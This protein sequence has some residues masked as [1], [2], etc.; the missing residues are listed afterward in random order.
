M[1]EYEKQKKTSIMSVLKEALS[2]PG[3]MGLSMRIK[4]F[5]T[6]IVLLITMFFG[7]LVVLTITGTFTAGL[8]ET[9]RDIDEQLTHI[10]KDIENQ[11]GQL[12]IQGVELSEELSSSI[13]RKLADK[14]LTTRDLKNHPEVLEEIIS[15]EYDRCMFALLRSKSSGVFMI[16]DS[17]VNP[18]LNNG[19]NSRAG[20]YIKNN[21]P[22]ILSSSS[23]NILMLRGSSS[24]ARQNSITLHSQWRMEFDISNAPYFKYPIEEAKKS[25]LPLSRLYYWNPSMAL[26]ET[27]EKIMLV[28]IPLI[29]SSG[30]AFG[31]CGFDISAM[32]FK[33]SHMPDNS[34]YNRIFCVFAPYSG[35]SLDTDKAFFSGGYSVRKIAEENQRLKV[36]RGK[37]FYSYNQDDGREFVGLH[38]LVNIYPE[39]SPFKEEKWAAALIMPR[40][41]IV[42][43]ITKLNI[44]ITLLFILLLLI[45][46][47]ISLYLSKR[48]IMPITKSIDII[49]SN[50]YGSVLKTNI[51]EIDDLMEFLSTHIEENKTKETSVERVEKGIASEV[52]PSS[53]FDEFVKNTKNLSP[54]ERA[55]F[56]L[57]VEGY[58]AKE[59]T[60][61]L[62]LSINTIKTHNKRIYMKLNVTSREELLLYVNMLKEA[63]RE[64]KYR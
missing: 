10:S 44:E 62:N 12:S 28:S 11:Y 15:G 52:L 63:G 61:I 16:L 1:E 25:N 32:L 23:P 53:L 2:K 30:N 33:L 45:G 8:R 36:E 54:A 47:F 40:E 24:I 19:E 58:T 26:P 48:Y 3:E 56:N 55:V 60:G 46:I 37:D 64:V 39:G 27:S 4:L 42:G 6:L 49:K 13:E 14:K 43:F 51:H 5:I 31:V 22:N 34:V 17:T 38:R 21:E 9:K 35:D 59:I 50:N 29:D 7:V 18:S 20:I 57:Y 41:D